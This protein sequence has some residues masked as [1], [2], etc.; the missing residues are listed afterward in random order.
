MVTT[1][2]VF[3]LHIGFVL[4]NTVMILVSLNACI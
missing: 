4:L 1:I 2:L 3:K